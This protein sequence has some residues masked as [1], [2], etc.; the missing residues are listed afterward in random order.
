MPQYECIISERVS[1]QQND[2]W[3]VSV[4]YKLSSHKIIIKTSG[5]CPSVSISKTKIYEKSTTNHTS[6]DRNE[7]PPLKGIVVTWREYLT[8]SKEKSMSQCEKD[9]ARW[10]ASTKMHSDMIM[11]KCKLVS[12]RSIANEKVMPSVGQT[13][14]WLNSA[15]CSHMCP[16][17]EPIISKICQ[18]WW[19]GYAI[20]ITSKKSPNHISYSNVKWI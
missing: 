19:E 4:W 2:L 17:P 7:P 1:S 15:A 8:S 3:K 12:L 10:Y 18:Q 20:V 6:S 9:Q 13:L 16:C 5:L 11:P 14:K